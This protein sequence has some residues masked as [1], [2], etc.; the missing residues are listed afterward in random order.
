MSDL[1][2]ERYQAARAERLK[3]KYGAEIPEFTVGDLMSAIFSV[4]ND[5]DARA[6]FDCYVADI[7]TQM[8]AG[9][10]QGQGTAIDAAR[11]NIG[12]TTG[13]GMAPERIEMWARVTSSAHPILGYLGGPPRSAAEIVQ[14]GRDAA[15]RDI[16]ASDRTN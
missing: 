11:S 16:E 7:Q 12:W 1:F 15:R 3:S 8:D 13:E 4:D 2:M 10:W 14:A 9:K 6:F 5:D